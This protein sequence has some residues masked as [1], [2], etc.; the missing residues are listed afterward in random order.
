VRIDRESLRSLSGVSNS[1]VSTAEVSVIDGR[2]LELEERRVT[3]AA[4][5]SQTETVQIR[6]LSLPPPC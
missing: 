3:R 1:I 5:G 6:R 2:V 4:R